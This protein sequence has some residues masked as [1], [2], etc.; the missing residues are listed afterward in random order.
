MSQEQLRE[1]LNPC[2]HCGNTHTVKVVS[3]SEM[4]DEDAD[5]PYMHTDS[6]AVI[7]DA[8]APDGPGGCGACSGFKFT[9]DEAVQLWNTRATQ[10]EQIVAPSIHEQDAKAYKSILDEARAALGLSD[11]DSL[12][13]AIERLATQ[14]EQANGDEAVA[15]RWFNSNGDQVTTWLEVDP[16]QRASIEAQVSEAGWRIEY[17]Y[18]RA[19]LALHPAQAGG[20]MT[21]AWADGVQA[22]A[23]LLK[24]MADEMAM[25]RGETDPDTGAIQFKSAATRE[26]HAS[27]GELAEE[28]ERLK[29]THHGITDKGGA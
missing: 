29:P 24:R 19:L 15:W 20:T 18:A 10:P 27:L 17:A 5:G 11:G 2:P 8:S 21:D 4:W 3:S 7:C 13:A 23:D 1:A 12:V 6:Y 16:S 25:E 14:P 28:I 9:V 22:A 26:W